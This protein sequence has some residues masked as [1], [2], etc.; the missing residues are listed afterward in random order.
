MRT[1]SILVATWDDGLFS[2]TERTVRQELAD[3]AVRSLVADVQGAVLAIVGGH[4]LF[5]R[6]SD[7]Q[8]NEVADS[9]FD[10]SCCVPIADAVFVG[11]DDARILRVAAGGTQQFLPGFDAVE[12]RDKWYAGTAI[13]DG[14]LMGPPLGVRSMAATCDGS[15][16]LANI[17]VGGIPRSTDAGV[18]WR[19]TIDI[20][21]DVHQ[22]CAHPSR[23]DLVIAAAAKG[24]CISRD[25]GATWTIEARGL[26]APHCSA[27]AFGRNDI[28]VSASTDPFAPQGA[29]YRRPIDGN[30]PLRPLG[31]G[32]PEWTQG[33]ADT[34]CIATRDSTVAVIDRSG[35]LY[36]SYDDGATWASPFDRLPTPSGLHIS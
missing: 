4:S 27:V 13:V 24:L 29:V 2:V 33:S 26:H 23:P 6:S 22:V 36:V 31:G 8:W 5:R 21:S 14:K 34:D 28:F 3:R 11:T 20:D 10:L 19:P 7:G 25:G 17:H 15:V 16:L 18:T 9:D 35:H 1:P 12:G 32:M 30:G